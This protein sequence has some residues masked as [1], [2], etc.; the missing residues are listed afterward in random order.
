MN[1]SDPTPPPLPV[2]VTEPVVAEPA[3]SADRAAGPTPERPQ[4]LAARGA[5]ALV[6]AYQRVFAGRPS[7]C[8]YVPTC[9]TYALEAL[10]AHGFFG[11]L[12]LSTKRIARCNP[13]GG[14]GYDPVPERHTHD[15]VHTHPHGRPV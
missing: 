6:R 13:W 11:G 7:P 3:V 12:W 2:A 14:T 8:R 9:S 5:Y 15:G 1:M 4:G 10:A